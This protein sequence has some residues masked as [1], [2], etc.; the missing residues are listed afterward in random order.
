MKSRLHKN[1]LLWTGFLLITFSGVVFSATTQTLEQRCNCDDKTLEEYFDFA[2]HVVFGEVKTVNNH[3]KDLATGEFKPMQAF[4]GDKAFVQKLVGTAIESQEHCRKR[5]EPGFYLV[6][7]KDAQNVVINRCGNSRLLKDD[8]VSTLTQVKKHAD[9]KK[10]AAS[11][12][13]QQGVVTKK[14][15]G[16]STKPQNESWL[17]Q[18]SSWIGD[19]FE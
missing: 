11:G 5:L 10:S 3:G 19:L 6:F 8:L 7:T 15:S 12:A 17:D 1:Y 14:P 4:K 16:Q 9:S 13:Q 18:L 2:D